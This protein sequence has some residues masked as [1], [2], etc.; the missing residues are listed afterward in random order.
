MEAHIQNRARRGNRRRRRSSLSSV[1]WV[2]EVIIHH[3]THFYLLIHW[4]VLAQ[5]LMTKI[6]RQASFHF[7]TLTFQLFFQLQR[8]LL[9]F[10][11]QLGENVVLFLTL[12][13]SLMMMIFTLIKSVQFFVVFHRTC[14]CEANGIAHWRWYIS[15]TFRQLILSCRFVVHIFFHALRV[16]TDARYIS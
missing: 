16:S 9:L 4:N 6:P 12:S 7:A 8:S 3:S 13:S 11:F 2:E 14:A 1:G 10:D 5:M 15:H